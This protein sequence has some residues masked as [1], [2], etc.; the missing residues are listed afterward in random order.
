MARI[1]IVDDEESLRI[2]LQT[3]LELEGFDVT[4]AES[5]E[6]ALTMDVAGFDLVLLDIMMGGMSGTDMAK[7]L[8]EDPATADVPII[9]LTAKT[10]AED[11]VSGLDVG[12]DD[13]IVK[14]YSVKNVIARIEAVIRRTGRHAPAFE[15]IPE[16]IEIDR[17]NSLAIVDGEEVLLPREELEILALLMENPGQYFSSQDLRYAML[18]VDVI[19]AIDR[20]AEIINR[21][22]E[23]I[24]PYDNHIV[25][26]TDKGYGWED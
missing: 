16:G 17:D 21:L 25:I 23:H 13:Y 6:M 8:K 24:S 5:A 11:M 20:I 26:D 18:K 9:F 12:A 1:L 3:Y 2:G 4:T 19:V 10:G 22:C 7:I 15:E 14:P